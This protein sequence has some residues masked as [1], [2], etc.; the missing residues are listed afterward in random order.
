[1]TLIITTLTACT[2]ESHYTRSDLI[3]TWVGPAGA[4]I[5]ITT[6]GR[7]RLNNLS[8]KA[9]TLGRETSGAVSGSA[10]WKIEADGTEQN[11]VFGGIDVTPTRFDKHGWTGDYTA[12]PRPTLFFYQRDPDQNIRYELHRSSQ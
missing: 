2:T 5:V 3:G 4:S 12:S 1:M 8:V 9:V 10:S 7:A 11:I 6:G